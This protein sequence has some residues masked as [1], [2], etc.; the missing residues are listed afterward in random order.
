MSGKLRFSLAIAFYV[1]VTACGGGGSGSGGDGGTPPVS[2]APTVTISASPSTVAPNTAVTVTWSS[3]NATSCTASGDWSGTR[4]TAGSE[5]V[6]VSENVTFNLTCSGA[7]GSGQASASVEVTPAPVLDFSAANSTI[8]EGGSVELNWSATAATS[9]SASGGWS[10]DKP[11][12]GTESI[13]DLSQTTAFS[14]T[15]SGSGGQTTRSV[16]VNVN[17]RPK[18]EVSNLVI[19]QANTDWQINYRVIG[20]ETGSAVLE[21]VDPPTQGA[22]SIASGLRYSRVEWA[23]F[24]DEF[25]V[26][27]VANGLRSDPVTVSVEFLDTNGNEVPDFV[28]AELGNAVLLDGIENASRDLDAGVYLVRETW[29]IGPSA[30]LTIRPSSTIYLFDDAGIAIAGTLRILGAVGSPVRMLPARIDPLGWGGIAFLSGAIPSTLDASKNYVSG[31]VLKGLELAGFS[32]GTNAALITTCDSVASTYLLENVFIHNSIGTSGIEFVDKCSQLSAGPVYIAKGSVFEL[33]DRDFTTGFPSEVFDA[34][35]T[36]F[37]AYDTTFRGYSTITAV[38][39]PEVLD[40]CQLLISPVSNSNIAG[41]EITY[42]SSTP[43]SVTNSI[44]N[45]GVIVNLGASFLALPNPPITDGNIF[46]QGSADYLVTMMGG[47]PGQ[48]YQFGA[49]YFAP[50]GELADAILDGT[51]DVSRPFADLSLRLAE[52]PAAGPRDTDLDGDGVTDDVDPNPLLA[53]Q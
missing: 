31:S 14:L 24:T 32:E 10:G 11:V 30:A 8:N 25:S 3:T 33:D 34:V 17:Q 1:T 35:N 51:R 36:R 52:P 42:S 15:C 39:Q 13:A 27:A 43:V 28:D 19:D 49:S 4:A 47:T 29:Q 18:L 5:Q 12:S 22:V 48:T 21:I 23:F 26:V 40:Y 38:Y 41:L 46:R 7:G 37:E 44:V 6:N 53:G 20:D 45:E 9:C 16:T 50:V 2:P